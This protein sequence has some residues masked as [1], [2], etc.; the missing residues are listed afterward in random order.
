MAA[1]PPVPA[2]T[3]RNLFGVAGAMMLLTAAEA[4]PAKAAELDGELLS[5]C[6]EAD[7]LE[8]LSDAMVVGL[9][10]SGRCPVWAEAD[11]LGDE[12]YSLRERVVA[13]PARTPE[14]LQAKALLV[15]SRLEDN[16]LACGLALSLARDVLG[17]AGA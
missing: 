9:P 12:A 16:G 1:I 6:A 15:L 8:A 3:R 14:G 5:C 17:R 4:G 11:R 13:M 7:R 10:S 2:A